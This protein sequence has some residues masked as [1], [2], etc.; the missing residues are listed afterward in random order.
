[1]H[2]PAVLAVILNIQ[3][4]IYVAASVVNV[5]RIGAKLARHPPAHKAEP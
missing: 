5:L 4:I 1:M 2:T 3:V